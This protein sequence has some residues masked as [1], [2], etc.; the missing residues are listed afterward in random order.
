MAIPNMN[1][2]RTQGRYRGR[3][4]H[5][6]RLFSAVPHW[7]PNSERGLLRRHAARRACSRTLRSRALPAASGAERCSPAAGQA[8]GEPA[9]NLPS[10]AGAHRGSKAKAD[11]RKTPGEH[12][13]QPSN[14]AVPRP[15]RAGLRQQGEEFS[16]CRTQRA[17]PEPG[18]RLTPALCEITASG[19]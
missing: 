1:P 7:A 18:V 13:G 4:S 8:A 3:S 11:P 19:A 10:R 14:I 12:P 2:S 15:L 6:S 9:S 5:T 17:R 16:S